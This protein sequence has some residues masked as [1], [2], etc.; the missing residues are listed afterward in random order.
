MSFF[1]TRNVLAPYVEAARSDAPA[2][3]ILARTL[4]SAAIV[5]VTAAHASRA[6]AATSTSMLVV[7]FGLIGFTAGAVVSSTVAFQSFT[8][9]AAITSSSAPHAGAVRVA[10]P[11]VAPQ[12]VAPPSAA[13][14]EV[15]PGPEI[16]QPPPMARAEESPPRRPA[17]PRAPAPR[18]Q[19]RPLDPSTLE[20]ALQVDAESRLVEAARTRLRTAPWTT[21][22]LVHEHASRFPSGLL[23]IEREVLAIDALVALGRREEAAVR[24]RAL[25]AA[26]P[27]SAHIAS[28]E[29][30]VRTIG[31][32]E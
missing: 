22:E 14:A 2:P 16:K 17:A 10:R 23:A 29:R 1:R 13:F 20:P 24:L 12:S 6:V 15:D 30:R 18:E 19:P 11:S 8:A 26:H 32:H 28:L 25:K 31:A 21:L 4:G 27:D 7:K 9:P 5:A 3:A